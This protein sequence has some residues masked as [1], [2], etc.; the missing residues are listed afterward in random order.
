MQIDIN[1][2]HQ[3]KKI[4][5]IFDQFTHILKAFQKH[6]NVFYLAG[7][8]QVL[9]FDLIQQTVKYAQVNTLPLSIYPNLVSARQKFGTAFSYGDGKFGGSG[10]TIYGDDNKQIRAPSYPVFCIHKNNFSSGKIATF[11]DS[12]HIFKSRTFSITDFSA[13]SENGNFF[14]QNFGEIQLYKAG[15]RKITDNVIIQNNGAILQIQNQ[16][17]LINFETIKTDLQQNIN[18]QQQPQCFTVNNVEFYKNGIIKTKNATITLPKQQTVINAIHFNE[19]IICLHKNGSISSYKNNF[20]QLQ[21]TSQN[22]GLFVFKDTIYLLEFN[23]T[24]KLYQVH[25][26][27]FGTIVLFLIKEE[28]IQGIRIKNQINIQAQQNRVNCHFLDNTI[29]QITNLYQK[30]KVIQSQQLADK[31]INSGCYSKY[32]QLLFTGSEDGNLQV[33]NSN[34][35]L[36]FHLNL[37]TSIKSITLLNSTDQTI[38]IAVGCCQN[39]L[40]VFLF[41]YQDGILLFQSKSCSK[42]KRLTANM[43]YNALCTILSGE[44]PVFAAGDSTGKIFIYLF[45]QKEFH[46]IS[47]LQ[48]DF[49]IFFIELHNESLIVSGS[50]GV[51][52]FVIDFRLLQISNLETI[53]STFQQVKNCENLVQDLVISTTILAKDTVVHCTSK[54]LFAYDSGVGFGAI[55]GVLT[56][57]REGDFEYLVGWDRKVKIYEKGKLQQ[58]VQVPIYQ[59]HQMVK[60]ERGI[61]ILGNGICVLVLQ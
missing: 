48:V 41:T 59:I 8:Y 29:L 53:K 15:I 45:K 7:Q 34:L 36:I 32:T 31:E 43:K 12:C 10:S 5:P 55:S 35:K 27:E 50:R 46:L 18:F 30:V 3:I 39:Q 14:D 47:F 16:Q 57:L 24:V 54:G 20:L 26:E 13:G 28:F 51:V 33:Y 40:Y 49:S 61:A 19:D 38:Q 42:F 60:I 37:H 21:Q 1:N 9:E 6:N 17:Q 58:V 11:T 44:F 4:S 22:S 56:C 52:Q 25:L 23:K 2:C